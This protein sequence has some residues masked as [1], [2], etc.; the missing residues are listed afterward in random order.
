MK[1]YFNDCGYMGLIDGQYLQ[2]AT[3]TDYYEMF[4]DR[5]QDTY[6]QPLPAIEMNIVEGVPAAYPLVLLNAS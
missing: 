5:H 3:E 6:E 4:E 2:F 1:G